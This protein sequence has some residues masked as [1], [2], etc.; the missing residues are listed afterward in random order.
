[1][2]PEREGNRSLSQL[3]VDLQRES[4]T[5][6]RDEVAL[7]RT[8]INDKI[9]Q[10]SRGAISLAGGALVSFA[11]LIIVLMALSELLI[12]F[13]IAR[14]L[15]F[16]IVGGVVLIIGLIMLAKGRSNLKATHLAPERSA[17][18]L[19]RDRDMVKEQVQ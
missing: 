7:V 8:E 9:A 4:T 17:H 11:A 1:M 10:V 12:Q 5:L 6:V 2:E 15:S 14:W 18:S 13:E 19:Q 3:I 16:L